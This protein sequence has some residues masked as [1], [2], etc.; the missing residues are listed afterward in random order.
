MAI[1]SDDA[2]RLVTGL[3]WP[4]V[5]VVLAVLFRREL[6]AFLEGISGLIRGG[7]SKVS[8]PGGFAFELV[9]TNEFKI[10][11]SAP[12]GGDLRNTVAIGQFASGVQDI[13]GLLKPPQASQAADYA[14]FDL[15]SGDKWLTSRLHLFSLLLRRTH[16]LRYCVFVYEASE[17]PRRSLGFAT[18]EV[19]RWSLARKYP[20]LERA[21]H[22]ASLGLTDDRI[23]SHTGAFDPQTAT[24]FINNYL[25]AIQITPL[26]ST[27]DFGNDLKGFAKNLLEGPGLSAFLRSQLPEA[28]L[29]V[30]RAD[31]QWSGQLY[32]VAEAINAVMEKQSLYEEAR[33]PG[34]QLSD[35][36]KRLINLKPEGDERILLNRFLLHEGCPQFF[37]PVLPLAASSSF[38]IEEWV[39]LPTRDTTGIVRTTWERARWIQRASVEE[40]LG[41]DLGR[42]QVQMASLQAVSRKDQMSMILRSEGGMI[43]IVGDG[44]RFDRLV[45]RL[46][47]A[48]R[49]IEF[50]L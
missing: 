8:L 6:S 31:L 2:V 49:A 38:N 29:K 10:D 50:Y 23:I 36:T 37:A 35:E 40:L 21:A 12:G 11:W 5:V 3:I 46:A 19:V 4:V 14:V 34:I 18:T 24:F 22:Q 44:G 47:L 30:L 17:V 1:K 42:T 13:L 41:S 16:G 25:K 32:P 15:G 27:E 28:A 45:D 48:A 20:H 9:K 26:V 7:L 33:F 43:A 39:K